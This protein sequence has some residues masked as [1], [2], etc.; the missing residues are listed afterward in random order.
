MSPRRRAVADRTPCKV[1]GTMVLNK[2]STAECGLCAVFYPRNNCYWFVF[3]LC[4][5]ME[6]AIP[7]PRPFESIAPQRL[8]ARTSSGYLLNRSAGGMECPPLCK[9]P[10][11]SQ[12][13]LDSKPHVVR[14]RGD[15]PGSDHCSSDMRRRG[16]RVFSYHNGANHSYVP[17]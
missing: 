14:L 15:H 3:P 2:T 9:G 11:A 7:S 6:E 5:E 16:G 8:A 4:G 17:W 13:L 12:P 1:V 10:F